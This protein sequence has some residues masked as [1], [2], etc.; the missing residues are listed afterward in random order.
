MFRV[1]I[2]E[3]ANEE[4]RKRWPQRGHLGRCH[5]CSRWQTA[6][7]TLYFSRKTPLRP[8][9]SPS[10]MDESTKSCRRN[11]SRARITCRSM[12]CTTGY[13]SNAPFTKGYPP[14]AIQT[15]GSQKG[16]G[17]PCSGARRTMRMWLGCSSSRPKPS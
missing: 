16:A 9:L 4:S 14:H 1:N 7:T 17:R 2:A 13:G 15:K 8:F 3:L 10:L 5:G 11:C 12:T 6:L